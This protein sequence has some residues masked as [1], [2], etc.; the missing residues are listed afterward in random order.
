[1]W[2]HLSKWVEESDE[3]DYERRE[4]Y[5]MFGSIE[6]HINAYAFIKSEADNITNIQLDLL[7]PV[8]RRDD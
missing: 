3:Y 4:P 8:K 2:Q 6:E 1:M 5:G 7:I